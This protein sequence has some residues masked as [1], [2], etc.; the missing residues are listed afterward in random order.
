MVYVLPK[1]GVA[2]DFL[3]RC[4]YIPKFVYMYMQLQAYVYLYVCAYT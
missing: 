3:S 4:M 1:S 2:N